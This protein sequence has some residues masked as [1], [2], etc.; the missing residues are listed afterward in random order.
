MRGQV[1]WLFGVSGA[2]KTTQA[3][4]LAAHIPG[5]VILD[6]D[7]M[8]HTVSK[9]LG[10]S[11]YD[12]ATHLFRMAHIASVISRAGH[13]VICAFIT[14]TDGIR[15]MIEG[16][17]PNVT[18]IWLHARPKKY[19]F[20]ENPAKYHIKCNTDKETPQQTTENILRRIGIEA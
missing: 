2:G 10:F 14:P 6:G 18:W 13:H 8:R 17:V 11:I 19:K 1:L 5:A 16:I 4:A 3:D 20:F 9:D 7:Y 15:T 12:R